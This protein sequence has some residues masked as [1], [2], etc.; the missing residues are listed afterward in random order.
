ML[1]DWSLTSINTPLALQIEFNDDSEARACEIAVYALSFDPEVRVKFIVLFLITS[2]GIKKQQ[3]F[4]SSPI[5]SS[6]DKLYD[7]FVPY[8]EAI[9]INHIF[10]CMT[11]RQLLSTCKYSSTIVIGFD[12][13]FHPLGLRLIST[14]ETADTFKT[15]RVVNVIQQPYDN[16]HVTA[17]GAAGITSAMCELL[18]F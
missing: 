17:D 18:Q 3:Y 16:T 2:S 8:C 13:H 10:I 1:Y 12:P 5:C 7:V 11:T 9:D 15:F 6:G 4:D 14:D